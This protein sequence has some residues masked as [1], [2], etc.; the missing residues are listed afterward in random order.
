MEDL[1]N[2]PS[3]LKELMEE[4]E[5]KSETLAAAVQISGSAIRAWLRGESVPTYLNAAKLADFFGCSLDFLMGRTDY[6]A[7]VPR[8]LP[9]FYPQLRK[10]MAEANVTR[11]EI[12]ENTNIKDA[13]FTN[14]AKGQLPLIVTLCTLADYLHVSLDYLIGRRDY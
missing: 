6:E 7:A 4:R 14:W 1:S 11:F 12:A 8:P 9:P 13:F 2:F 10:V 5:L 3:R